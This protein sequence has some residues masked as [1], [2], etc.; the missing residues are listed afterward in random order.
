MINEETA[1]I[2]EAARGRTPTMI[3]AANESL[4][5]SENSGTTII[6]ISGESVEAVS[7]QENR[8]GNENAPL[9]AETA[10]G[11]AKYH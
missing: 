10:A 7:K 2:A 6:L 9:A 1:A 3:D 11:T 8:T 4:V 5:A